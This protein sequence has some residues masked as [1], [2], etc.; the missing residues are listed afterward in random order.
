M[1]VE[2]RKSPPYAMVEVQQDIELYRGTES[3]EELLALLIPLIRASTRER[4]NL[5]WRMARF[6]E[7]R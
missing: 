2:E 1:E 7:E 6:G 4:E 5:S 3:Y